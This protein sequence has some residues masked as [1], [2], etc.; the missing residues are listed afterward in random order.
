MRF[1]HNTRCLQALI[2]IQIFFY[3]G[4]VPALLSAPISIFRPKIGVPAFPLT[5]GIFDVEIE[6]APG[7]AANGWS[8]LLANDLRSWTCSVQRVAYG[9]YVNCNSRTGYL[10]SVRAPAAISPEVFN[11]TVQHASAGSAASRHS[12]KILRNYETNFYILHYADPQVEKEKATLANGVGGRH[13]SIQAIYWAV[14]A[15]N[16]INPRFMFNTGDEVDNGIEVLYPKYLD[17]ITTLDV[18]LLIT[19]GNNDCGNFDNW[20]RDIGQPTY[21]ITLGSFYICMKDYESNDNLAWFTNNY[22]ESFANTNITFRLFGQHYNTGDCCYAPPPGQYPD[23]ML[24]G[25]N[26]LFATL[27]IDPY[28][29]LSTRKAWDYGASAIFEFIKNDRGWTCPNKTIHG[30]SNKLLLYG[31][32]GQ[33][34]Y[35]TNSFL[36]SNNGTEFT[37]TTFITN[38]L[39]YDFWDGRV[40]FLMRKTGS[41]YAVSNGEKVAEYD[42]TA[43]NTAVLVKVNIRRNSLTTVTVAPDATPARP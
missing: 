21:S 23:L 3:L 25:H 9:R 27:R 42:Y 26:H 12:V 6:A 43:T 4:L 35:V 28:F 2:A 31:D 34:C 7:L 15:I 10:L 1:T 19:R 29:V 16:L 13:G 14:P 24:V 22:A 32:W 38:G 17:A 37:N 36:H 8:A 40:C 39:D 30:T 5:N 33:P 41:G 20:Q 11:L 18:P